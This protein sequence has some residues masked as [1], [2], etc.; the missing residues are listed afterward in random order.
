MLDFRIHTFLAVCRTMNFTEAARQLHITQPAVSQHIHA[1][2]KEYGTQL[3]GY[4]GKKLELTDSGQLLF[5]A[6][7]AMNHDIRHLQ[8]Q[9]RQI[10]SRRS[11]YFGATLTI[12]EY[13]MPEALIRLL[14]REPEIR[15][16]MLIGNT[17]ELLRLMDHGEI[18]FAVVEG[19]FPNHV[20]DSLVWKKERF[21]PVCS[22][23]Y[24]FAG[25]AASLK[26][27]PGERLLVRESG[28]GTREVL[29]RALREHN[30]LLEDFMLLT[31]LGN[32]NV[33]KTL[34]SAG[35]GISF[36]YESVVKKELDSGELREIELGDFSLSHEFSFLW[37]KGS[38]FA[39]YY[40]DMFGMLRWDAQEGGVS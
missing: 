22:P 25:T 8:E 9:I 35:A 40:R 28:S 15:L 34:V 27:L 14:R 37:Q 20:Y 24:E 31:E 11:M 12:G 16:R 38:Q 36:F 13:I 21:V 4:Q 39:S 29:E 26:D 30:I 19:F 7:N 5:Q 33:I 23:A 2:E 32:L 3:F 18:D 17:E 1:L 10:A 6:A